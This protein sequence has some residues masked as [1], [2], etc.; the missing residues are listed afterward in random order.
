MTVFLCL[1][2]WLFFCAFVISFCL[3]LVWACSQMALI[4][5]HYASDGIFFFLPPWKRPKLQPSRQEKKAAPP[6]KS[7]NPF[8]DFCMRRTITIGGRGEEKGGNRESGNCYF[9]GRLFF[10]P[11][12]NVII[13]SFLVGLVYTSTNWN[14]SP[15]TSCKVLKSYQNL[16]VWQSVQCKCN[17]AY[18]IF[19]VPGVNL[20]LYH[21]FA[22]PSQE[23]QVTLPV[24]FN[25]TSETF[26]SKVAST[27]EV[28]RP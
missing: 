17:R 13:F 18:N 9:L 20:T 21:L 8:R 5:L 15:K 2:V 12:R 25:S 4:G 1:F 19:L 28:R 16:V 7:H 3:S 14:A 11:A 27:E 6:E 22:F 24:L 10:Y 26:F 23:T